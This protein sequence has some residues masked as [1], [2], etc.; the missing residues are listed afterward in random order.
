M[1]WYW[2]FWYLFRFSY[3]RT[4]QNWEKIVIGQS[5]FF[6]SVK[7]KWKKKDHVIFYIKTF[8]NCRVIDIQSLLFF[9]YFFQLLKEFQM[10][11]PQLEYYL[12]LWSRNCDQDMESITLNE[13]MA[14]LHNTGKD[15][16]NQWLNTTN[17][18]RNL[19]IQ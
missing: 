4:A 10:T 1:F 17:L 9:S 5:I 14:F 7:S 6:P 12:R 11:K 16:I 8:T 19:E 2:I 18:Y 15:G 13:W 3:T